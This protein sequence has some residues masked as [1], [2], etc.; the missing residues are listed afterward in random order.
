[1]RESH[2]TFANHHARRYHELR[3]ALKAD[4]MIASPLGCRCTHWRGERAC[5]GEEAELVYGRDGRSD[6][7][8]AR[9]ACHVEACGLERRRGGG[10]PRDL[11]VAAGSRCRSHQTGGQ[12][13][14]DKVSLEAPAGVSPC[15]RVWARC[16]GDRRN[17]FA[18][19]QHDAFGTA[20]K[21]IRQ[22]LARDTV[23]FGVRAPV[24]SP[25]ATSRAL[26]SSRNLSE[27]NSPT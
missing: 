5:V 8:S 14:R 4:V 15:R 18:V 10:Q 17:W 23:Q 1:M 6:D 19:D 27:A 22:H 9:A 24:G 26:S 25:R 20:R 3:A 13:P 11:R 16:Q 12:Q 2:R 21:E 7:S